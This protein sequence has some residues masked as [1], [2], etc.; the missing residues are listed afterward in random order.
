MTIDTIFR[1]FQTPGTAPARS[2][3]SGL[4]VPAAPIVRLTIGRIG[5]TKTFNA[6]FSASTTVYEVKQP[7]EVTQE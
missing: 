2:S 6:S 3:P 4:S 1:P 5:A 7:K